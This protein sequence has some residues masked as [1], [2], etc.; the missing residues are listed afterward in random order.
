MNASRSGWILFLTVTIVLAGCGQGHRARRG[1]GQLADAP[2]IVQDAAEA[3][4][5]RKWRDVARLEADMTLVLYNQRR[6][7]LPGRL[8]VSLA[9][10]RLVAWGSTARGDWKVTT[11]STGDI[12]ARGPGLNQK[13]LDLV[14]PALQVYLRR[15][16]GV[17]A[18]TGPT[19]VAG[20][21]TDA[22]VGGKRVTRLAV[23]GPSDDK[24][25]YFDKATKQ[26]TFVTTGSD[27]PSEKGLISRYEYQRL[28]EPG[29]ALPNP[30]RA[31]EIGDYVLKS[32]QPLWLVELTNV[33]LR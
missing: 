6:Y 19:R 28:A 13:E 20:E 26:L 2:R 1:S 30:V 27:T 23:E 11:G 12:D 7:L 33:R 3:V 31:F 5:A 32:S 24:A 21:A 8:E 14:A 15:L 10:D 4:D 22:F 18:L 25:Y 17:W 29:L 9:R 16:W